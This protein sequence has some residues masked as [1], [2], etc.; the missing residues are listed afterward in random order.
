LKL[1][2][3]GGEPKVGVAGEPRDLGGGGKSLSVSDHEGSGSRLGEGRQHAIMLRHG[4]GG[5]RAGFTKMIW[6]TKMIHTSF[7]KDRKKPEK[8]AGFLFKTHISILTSKTVYSVHFLF[9]I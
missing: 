4:G 6:L 9:K 2:I 7:T 8:S 5:S 1:S 3:G